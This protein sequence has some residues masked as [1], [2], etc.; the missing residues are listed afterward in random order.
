MFKL[1]L[2]DDP[3][4]PADF[5]KRLDRMSMQR[6]INQFQKSI[7]KF[8]ARANLSVRQGGGEALDEFV[9]DIASVTIRLTCSS[10]NFRAESISRISPITFPRGT[11]WPVIH[12]PLAPDD[13]LWPRQPETGAS[14]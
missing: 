12:S 10:P 4:F 3:D 5:D 9:H 11:V 1:A 8:A 13:L 2:A 6:G 7:A 14:D